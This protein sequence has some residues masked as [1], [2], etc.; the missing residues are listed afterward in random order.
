MSSCDE[1]SE[2]SKCRAFVSEDTPG[3]AAISEERS[4]T[5]RSSQWPRMQVRVK[6][7]FEMGKNTDECLNLRQSCGSNECTDGEMRWEFSSL[8]EVQAAL[9][10][11]DKIANGFESPDF[12]IMMGSGAQEDDQLESNKLEDVLGQA[13]VFHFSSIFQC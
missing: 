6:M 4:S 5:S 1:D 11:D 12:N 2:L 9:R 10:A 7:Y 3:R 13:I 8:R